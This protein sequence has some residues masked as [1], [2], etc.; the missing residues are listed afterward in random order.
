MLSALRIFAVAAVLPCFSWAAGGFTV[1]GGLNSSFMDVEAAEGEDLSNHLGF[2]L[3]FGFEKELS[4]VFSI[5]PEI[6]FETRGQDAEADDPFFGHVES[7]I[8]LLYLQVPVFAM[9]KVPL[10]KGALNFFAGPSLGI[11]LSAKGE[12]ELG[13]DEMSVDI[14]ES[15][16]PID[17]GV[18]AGA[19]IEFPAGTGTF[20][21]RPSYYVGFMDINDA[22]EDEEEEEED[23]SEALHSRNIK[24]KVGFRFPL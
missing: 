6:G 20:F 13:G 7:R 9:F 16:A 14:K 1:G 24:L 4:P 11:L 17:F 2:N 23:G 3:G 12:I 19:G 18:E 15:I 10:T 8:K 21:I 5:V 22:E